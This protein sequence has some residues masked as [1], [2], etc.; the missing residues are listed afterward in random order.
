[1]SR[2]LK[3]AK[4]TSEEIDSLPRDRT[5]F[6]MVVSPLEVHGPHLPLG[7]DVFVAEEIRK[8]CSEAL[9]S[10]GR[11]DFLVEF[12]SYFLG[13]DTIPGSAKINHRA[14]YHLLLGTG[15]FLSER[16]F[17]YLLVLDNHG[18]PRHQIGIARAARGLRKKGF[19]LIAPFLDFYR[20]MVE[21]DEELRKRLDA[22]PGEMGD[23]QDCHAGHNETGLVLRMAPD[24]VRGDWKE[25]PERKID[26]RSFP[27][28][29]M[30]GLGRLAAALGLKELGRDLDY[31]GMMLSWV[32][33]RDPST[34]I[35]C[36]ATASPEAGERM[37]RAFSEE[38]VRQTLEALEGRCPE[39]RPLGWSLRFL[40]FIT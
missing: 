34:Y 25:L 7:T 23:V 18:G 33:S 37:L 20:K 40:A 14:I 15:E 3:I 11:V 9:L 17:R 24:L 29:M 31:L 32:T 28:L 13:S 16:G 35:G 39:Y 22:G 12:P 36:P 30:G 10:S 8:R 19:C 38:A 6:T 21:M 27:H 2:R 5:L 4:L 1:M 26:P